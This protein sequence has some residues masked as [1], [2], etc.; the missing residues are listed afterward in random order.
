MKDG[1]PFTIL[2]VDDDPDDRELIDEA[3]KEIDYEAEV[4]KFIDGKAL[5]NYLQ[6]ISPSMYPSLIVLDNSLPGMEVQDV[7]TLL[8]EIKQAQNIPVIIYSGTVST[9]KKEELLQL[10]AYK[11]IEKG[12]TMQA[13]A[14]AAKQ[15]KNIAE[16]FKKQTS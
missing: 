6:Q 8:K 16:A 1:L 11:V 3:F 15:L 14:D 12:V 10:G 9:A 4:K 7:L 13:V 2:V 5:I